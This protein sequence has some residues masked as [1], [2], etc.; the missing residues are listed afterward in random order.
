M[1]ALTLTIVAN[2]KAD[3]DKI[4]FVK[5]ELLK[6][7]D[8]TPAEKGCINRSARHPY[9]TMNL[10]SI[11]AAFLAL[12][13][14]IR[15]E[16]TAATKL[17]KERSKA[18]LPTVTQVSKSVYCA[19]GYSPANISMIVG[20]N[21]IVIVDTGMFPDDARA[22]MKEFRKVTQLPV[23]GVILTH[24]H[25]DHTGGLSAFMEAGPN[26]S[27]PA[28][29][30]RSPFNTEG[31]AF[32]AAGLTINGIRGARQ[33]GFLLPPEKR[34]NNGIAAASILRR[35]G[36]L[37][38]AAPPSRPIRL[39]TDGRRS[40]WQAW[41]WSWSRHPARLPMSFTCGF[42]R[43]ESSLPATT[44]IAHG[45]TSMPSGAPPIAMCSSGFTASR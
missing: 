17:L 20:T 45:R 2:I 4:D 11:T 22:V 12:C 15:A 36:T 26:G 6:L 25:G 41:N 5:A 7:I 27:K 35:I 8:V 16:E 28:V 43:S 29:Y 33:G 13:L 10:L 23:T 30:G 40:R 18:L 39:A 34:I 14:S 37:S 1:T 42:R 9:S 44:S 3:S 31:D 19:S 38:T 32:K 21:G 24:G